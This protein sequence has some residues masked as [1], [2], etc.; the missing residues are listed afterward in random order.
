VPTSPPTALPTLVPTATM[1]P[2]LALTE[3]P[4]SVPTLQPTPLPRDCVGS[5]SAC[6]TNCRTVYLISVWRYGT[7]VQC[8][9][10]DGQEDV[11]GSG[12]GDC[13]FDLPCEEEF[14]DCESACA[15]IHRVSG[16]NCSY[17][18]EGILQCVAGE[19]ECTAK[20]TPAPTSVQPTRTPIKCHPY[21]ICDAERCAD[22]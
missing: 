12:E 15:R 1:M 20:P 7:G 9:F 6:D 17:A 16:K 8:K 13:V 3:T 5:W 18:G 19:G 2:T 14:T 11:C 10:N 4:I 21:T 22:C